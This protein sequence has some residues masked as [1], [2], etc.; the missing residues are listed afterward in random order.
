MHTNA[1]VSSE[2]SHWDYAESPREWALCMAASA[3]VGS[4]ATP[5]QS[6]QLVQGA[7]QTLDVELRGPLAML[8]APSDLFA[9]KSWTGAT[10]VESCRPALAP[11]SARQRH[12][13]VMFTFAE[14]HT[15]CMSAGVADMLYCVSADLTHNTVDRDT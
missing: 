10:G 5:T 11:H 8:Q 15:C 13:M 14:A 9:A 4:A 3:G 2:R 7:Q 1:A 6:T 12:G